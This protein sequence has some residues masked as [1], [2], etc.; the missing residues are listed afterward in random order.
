MSEVNVTQKQSLLAAVRNAL[1]TDWFFMQGSQDP[2]VAPNA[3]R[4][5]KDDIKETLENCHIQFKVYDQY[6]SAQTLI[7]SMIPDSPHGKEFIQDVT[8]FIQSTQPERP[9]VLLRK[10]PSAK[11]MSK[12]TFT[13]GDED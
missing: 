7:E 3:T 8:L 10:S 1:P 11:G 6:Q 9:K 5:F 13:L 12:T 2:F 4:H